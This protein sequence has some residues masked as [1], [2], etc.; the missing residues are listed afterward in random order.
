[1]TGLNDLVGTETGASEKMDKEVMR[2]THVRNKK[3][4]KEKVIFVR[5]RLNYA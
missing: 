2:K 3:A 5:I 4:N 1:M